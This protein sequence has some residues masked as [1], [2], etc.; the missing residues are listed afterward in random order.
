MRLKRILRLALLCLTG[1]LFYTT[2]ASA[3]QI[4]SPSLPVPPADSVASGDTVRLKQPFIIP[5]SLHYR[6]FGDGTFARGNVNRSLVILRTEVN[7]DGPVVS[8]TTNPRFAYGIQNG[9]LAEREL[10][11]DLFVD[12]YKKRK[13]YSFGL[14]TLE[15]SNL[16]GIN[17]RQLAGAGVGWRLHESERNKLSLTNAIIYEDTDFR[18]RAS[19]TT[20]R[21]S[22]RLKG[23]HSFF[24]DRMRI[25][26]ITFVQPS[27]LDVSNLRWNT[28]I[29]VE[30]PLSKWFTLR[31]SFE[32]SY[33]SLV[34]SG[35]QRNDS[36]L[37]VGFSIGNRK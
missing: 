33:E 13:V 34:E 37:T 20:L 18:T 12:L 19:Q 14:A 8:L 21:N 28:L 11:I 22:T 15:S 2:P 25:T 26:H 3:W 1:M 5:D 9:Q 27:L 4:E 7:Y 31:S 32:N 10:Y 30:L 17:F 24:A 16:R 6:F 23:K 35:R 36:R 29:S